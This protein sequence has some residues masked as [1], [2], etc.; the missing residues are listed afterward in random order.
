[1]PPLKILFLSAE[2]APFAK[3]GGL[4]DVCGSLP[5]ALAALGHDVRVIMPAY[6]PVEAALHSGKLG[7]RPHPLTLQVPMGHGPVAAG[8]LE[9]TLPGSSVPIYFIAE[10]NLFGNR[11]GFYGYQDD[12][13]RFAFFSRAA[14]DFAVAALGWRPDRWST[15][16]TGMPPPPSPGWRPRGKGIHA[17]PACRPCSQF[18]T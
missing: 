2:V 16:T 5:K 9:A 14:L 1:M 3:A 12:A 8:V 13:D 6:G 7:I 10:R 11:G 17:T 15:P 18:T 4:A